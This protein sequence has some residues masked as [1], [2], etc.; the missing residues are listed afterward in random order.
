MEDTTGTIVLKNPESKD[1]SLKFNHKQSGFY[2]VQYSEDLIKSLLPTI[3]SLPIAD[4]L[5]LVRDTFALA[6]SGVVPIS[7]PLDLLSSY[8]NETDYDVDSAIAGDIGSLLGLHREEDFYPS[9]QKLVRKMFIH[10]LERL[11][12]ESKPNEDPRDGLLRALV[13][14]MMGAANEESVV[15][16]ATDRFWAYVKDPKANPLSGD[17]KGTIY[18]ISIKNGGLKVREEL[19]KIYEATSSSEEQ[20]RILTTIGRV[21]CKRVDDNHIFRLNKDWGFTGI[22]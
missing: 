11:S 21:T 16:G 10:N 18:S 15:K 3:P 13:I 7:Q 14:G 20:V 22:M 4:R 8:T 6:S 1:A 12:W 9:L 5:G 17:L 19:I 2:R